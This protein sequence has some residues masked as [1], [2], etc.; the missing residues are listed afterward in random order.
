MK[1]ITRSIKITSER[2]K[3]AIE[4]INEVFDRVAEKEGW[5][6]ENK[7]KKAPKVKKSSI[8]N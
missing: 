5:V 8:N 6:F 3:K 1:L 2:Q 4:T 7:T